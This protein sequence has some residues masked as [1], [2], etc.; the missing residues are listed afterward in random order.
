MLGAIDLGLITGL[1]TLG[2]F[3]TFRVLN[4]ADLTV[5]G[6]FVTGGMVAA[7]GILAGWSPLLATALGFVTGCLAGV[8]T[9]LLNTIGRINPLLAGILTQTAIYSINLRIGGRANVSLLNQHTLISWL[10][11]FSSWQ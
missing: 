1:M 2:V 6:S 10:R 9:G 11:P 5:D 7:T 4:F 3:L 8:F